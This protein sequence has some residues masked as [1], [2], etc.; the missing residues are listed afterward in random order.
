MEKR[1]LI[2]IPPEQVRKLKELEAIRKDL[3]GYPT[4][5]KVHIL[6]QEKLREEFKQTIHQ[7]KSKE[8]WFEYIRELF[9]IHIIAPIAIGVIKYSEELIG[10]KF[11][12]ILVTSEGD[13]SWW[14]NYK[15]DIYNVGK[16][17][18]SNFNDKNFSKEYHDKYNKFFDK[19]RS[20]CIRLRKK[21]F[22]R[23]SDQGLLR[24]YTSFNELM[25]KFYALTFDIDAIDVYLE[26]KIRDKF[27]KQISEK[28]NFSSK[29]NI[30]TNPTTMS[31]VNEEELE[32][33]KIVKEIKEKE[34]LYELFNNDDETIMLTLKKK[35]KKITKKIDCLVQKY[36]W[37]GLGWNV[38]KE[39]DFKTYLSNI[40]NIL[41]SDK[42]I[43]DEIFR[44]TH[45]TE[46]SKK[47]K[48]KLEKELTFDNEL[49]FYLQIFEKYVLYHDYRKEMQM[50]G[51]SIMNK[52]LFEI[53]K[54]KGTN[55]EDLVW[56]WPFEIE[57]YLRTGKIDFENIRKRKEAYFII[58]TKEHIEELTGE[59]AIKRRKE[60]LTAQIEKIYDFKGISASTGRVKG[61]AKIC[62]SATEAIRKIEKGDI[63]VASMTLP[64]YVPAM[65][66][67]AAI[68]TDEGGI[69]CHAAIIARE[70]NIPCIVGTKIATKALKDN[71]LIEVNANHG[72]VKIIR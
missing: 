65:K 12:R 17:L 6:L 11:T 44:L 54:R 36:W 63:L 67:A 55:Y 7:T 4:S 37:T 28:K 52:F 26:E 14:C 68:V 5:K 58:V 59:E 47:E 32:L 10:E 56:A 48:K 49:K 70:M 19:T 39:K 64:D 18:L 29:Y 20:E 8:K 69:T 2:Q 72:R 57:Q 45:F 50:K 60:E 61:K 43:I 42:N 30:L 9:P 40:K 34:P 31:Y 13:K 53:A 15:E 71:M 23:F 33:Y 41:E 27:Q 3:E 62:F 16:Y 66:K 24:K 22:S 1:H 21:D 51:T 46:N 35:H 38:R 25:M